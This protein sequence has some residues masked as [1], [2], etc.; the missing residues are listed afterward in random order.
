MSTL[1]TGRRERVRWASMTDPSLTAAPASADLGHRLEEHR[2]ELTAHCYRML[3]SPF[4]AEDAV[5]ETLIRAWKGFDRFEGRAALRS[6][7]YSIATN[8]CLDMLNGRERR[9]RWIS[10]RRASRSRQ[11]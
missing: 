5:Q 2:R 1:S 4:E 3:G 11:T 8:V 9:A 6:W 7:L 10:G